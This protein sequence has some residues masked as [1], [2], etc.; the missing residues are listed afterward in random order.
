M[1][2]E[3]FIVLA[4]PH[5]TRTED[6][7]V[8]LFI[9]PR[10]DSDDPS[11]TL[12]MFGVFDHWERA[13]GRARITLRDQDGDLACARTDEHAVQRGLWKKMFPSSTPVGGQQLPDWS[14]RRVHSFD[15]R[16]VTTLAKVM[17]VGA[18]LASPLT[19]PA[20]SE[21]PFTPS[22]LRLAERFQRRDERYPE[23]RHRPQG[24][25]T[26]DE[27]MATEFL[28]KWMLGSQLP[29]VNGRTVEL[30]GAAS[31]ATFALRAAYE[32]HLA[33]RF[34]ERPES[35]M[36]YRDRPD[37]HAVP[38]VLPARPGEFHERVTMLGDHPAVLRKLGLVIDLHVEDLARLGRAQWLQGEI[39]VAGATC[40][41]TRVRCHRT[42]DGALVTVPD[43]PDWTDGALALG[44]PDRF[45][46]VDVDA[47]GSALKSERF[48]W[49]LPRMAKV[50]DNGDDIDAAHPAL[51]SAGFTLARRGQ[52]GV[53][54]ARMGTQH[55]YESALS[56]AD[57]LTTEL[58]TED[59]TRGMRI[60]VWDDHTK[61]WHSLHE[62]TS[63]VTVTGVADPV[64]GDPELGGVDNPGFIQGTAAS[65]T[66]GAPASAP[67]YVH[68]ALFGWEGW[69]LS[70]PRPGKRIRKATAAEMAAMPAN[71]RRSE[72]V[73]DADSSGDGTGRKSPHPFVF[74]HQVKGGTLPRLRFG[75]SYSF[76]A[77]QVDLA[78]NSRP[79]PGPTQAVAPSAL[80][81]SLEKL[82]PQDAADGAPLW[83]AALREVTASTVVSR[84]LRTAPEPVVD[85]EV[86]A[87]IAPRFSD[88]NRMRATSPGDSLRASRRSRIAEHAAHAATST[89]RPLVETT[90]KRD[91][92]SMTS[93]VAAHLSDLGLTGSISHQVVQALRTVT[94]PTPFL[95]WDPVQP[96][97]TVARRRFT[98]GESLRVLVVRSGVTQ[99][100]TTGAIA[101]TDPATYAASVPTGHG[102][103]ATSE[104]HLAPPKTTQMTAELHGKFDVGIGDSTKE[105]ARAQD[106]LAIA[107]TEDGTLL[108]KDRVDLDDPPNRVAQPGV[109]LV[110]SAAVPQVTPKTDLAAGEAPAPGQ[111]VVHD[112]DDLTLPYLPDPL[113]QGVSFVFPDA[114]RD[115]NLPAPFSGEGFTT[116]YPGAWPR[117]QPYRLVLGGAASLSGHVDGRVVHFDLPPG[118][119]QR[120]TVA[121]SLPPDGPDLLGPWR[122]VSD[123]FTS[124]PEVHEAAVD[125]WLWSLTP[126]E[127]YQ[128]VH[129]VPRPLEAPRPVRITPVRTLGQTP[130][131]LFG[132]LDLHGPST[133]SVSG[134]ASWTEVVDDLS[135]SGVVRTPTTETAFTTKIRPFEDI[136]VLA[137]AEKVIDY[138]GL[139]QIGFHDLTHHFKDTRHRTVSYRF[140]AS[141]RFR[142]YF[143]PA[144]LAPD[145]TVPLDDGRSVLSEPLVVE[146]PSSA[147]PAAPVVHSVVPLFRWDKGIEPEQ[148]V[149]RRHVRRAG[150]RIYLERPWFSSGDGELLAVLLAPTGRDWNG[151]AIGM[152]LPGSDVFGPPAKDD[153][154]FP[155]VSK[156]GGDPIWYAAEIKNRA[157]QPLQLDDVL[158]LAGYDDRDEAGRPVAAPG[159]LL[160]LP[161]FGTTYGVRVLG[162]RPQY[163][164]ERKLWYADVAL[165]PGQSLWSFVRL[166]VARYQPHS[167]DG[168]HLSAPVRC[169]Y[170]QLPPERTTSVSRTDGSH[171]RVVVSGPVGTRSHW[172]PDPRR[173]QGFEAAV[174]EYRKVVARL[175]KKDPTI[176]S[177]L[178][179]TTVT[180]QELTIRSADPGTHEV[181][182]VG[183]LGAGAEISLRQPVD[184]SASSDWRVTVE[185]WE[186][187]PGDP[188]APGQGEYRL[189]VPHPVWEQRLVYAD[190][191]TL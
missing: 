174:G 62:R 1:E 94:V 46:V 37:P 96:P 89:V 103:L 169:N 32:L 191:V 59:V 9:A 16:N 142:E 156:V 14:H 182:W 10:L 181:A 6:V 29:A 23:S 24:A 158:D 43:G 41:L 69:S 86:R 13:L 67:V 116:P 70:A 8:S 92:A 75:R 171:V 107:L 121:S 185:E 97:A 189:A 65:S 79:A 100:P 83:S 39:T 170:V 127:R 4:L 130:C 35:A 84:Q 146:V 81:A 157:L 154:G 163:N 76:R 7:H 18:V 109:S 115:R 178:G 90:T 186:Q 33:R 63:T 74:S 53:S 177:D 106:M 87:R 21:N 126:Q 176:A 136:A 30:T 148:P 168:C 129:A 42:A 19:A 17:Q 22:M 78:G 139:G 36:P 54:E 117:I 88:L 131:T 183:E 114:G 82:V 188:P 52:G 105:M 149:G 93:L 99:D 123:L 141:T 125:G 68:E 118:D 91:L 50:E 44:E 122:T 57:E 173:G 180:T 71:E 128:L 11:A 58:S 119:L 60:E 172:S 77:W 64:L 25:R 34:Y 38:T 47:D 104:R 138:P 164:E 113:A 166:A 153:S 66:P 150:V 190:E 49:S 161:A 31:G 145:P 162:Y 184:G 26:Y 175:Q 187:F 2:T 110:T 5:S 108:D 159:E 132:S 3:S 80:S 120:V 48:L 61:R 101:V 102:Y 12:R 20:V 134:E 151:S 165:D 167:V 95:R 40:K 160:D 15:V 147:R 143:A 179:W 124:E 135:L 137:G 98:E 152:L 111:Y 72:V 51:R 85:E 28:D 133:D 140:R 45:T 112:T 73:E 56:A 27:S 144:L 155:F 55:D